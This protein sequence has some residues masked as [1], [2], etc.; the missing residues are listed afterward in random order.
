[1]SN[2]IFVDR[3]RALEAQFFKHHDDEIIAKMKE[4]AQRVIAHDELHALTGIT[5]E[6]VLNALAD[7]KIG[8][9][10]AVL[11]MSLYPVIDV[12]WADG[13]PDE[14]ERKVVL[15]LAS[16]L[17][18]KAGSAAFTYLSRWLDEKPE[19]AWHGLWAEYTR[20]L[21][22]LMK[23]EDKAQLKHSVLGRARVVAEAS[24][25][26]LGVAFRVSDAEKAVLETLEKAFS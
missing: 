23:P 16:T 12:A 9:A 1:M 3:R 25:G 20:S 15:D 21:V 4:N 26:F 8:G 14:R 7:L 18:V 22:A 11:V 13:K 19:L 5:N 17:G 6:Q 2:E 10:A 24:G